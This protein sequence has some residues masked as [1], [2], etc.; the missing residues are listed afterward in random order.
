MC[1]IKIKSKLILKT[2]NITDLK[3]GE[4][5]HIH[6]FS[7]KILGAKLIAMGVLPNSTVELI[8]KTFFDSTYYIKI[9][10]NCNIALRKKEAISIIVSE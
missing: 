5:S 9:N 8:R 2:K 7:D 6:N 4:C 10:K 3:K 1:V